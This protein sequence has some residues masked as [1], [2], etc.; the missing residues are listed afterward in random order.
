MGYLSYFDEYTNEKGHTYSCDMLRLKFKY[1]KY[2]EIE[3]LNQINSINYSMHNDIDIQYYESFK[4]SGF[5]HLF[6]IKVFDSFERVDLSYTL[7]IGFRH[8]MHLSDSNFIGFIEF[9]PNKAITRF[10]VVKHF[11]EIINVYAQIQSNGHKYVLVRYDMAIDVKAPRQLFSIIKEGKRRYMYVQEK[12]VSEYLG[13]RLSDGYTKVY[14]KGEEQGLDI[15]MTRI[16]VTCESLESVAF[17]KIKYSVDSSFAMDDLNKTDKVLVA[18]ISLQPPERQHFYLKCL[19]RSKREKLKPYIFNT[20]NLFDF[21]K[22]GIIHVKNIVSSFLDGLGLGR[23]G[24]S[25][26]N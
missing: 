1:P 12:S 11:F 25:E 10:E 13:R 5:R 18:L 22:Q 3:I 2:L 24:R 21:D 14:D 4:D 26:V 16:E 6:V 8:N 20:D 9:N 19:G 17:P 7:T 23:S 15:D